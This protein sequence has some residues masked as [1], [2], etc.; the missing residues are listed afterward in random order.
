MSPEV[1]EALRVALRVIDALDALNV[2]YHVGG[3]YASSIHGVP[4]LTQDIDLVA[5]LPTH[6]IDPL[7]ES[8]AEE[9]YIDARSVRE[10]V[11]ERRSF[12]VIHLATGFKVDIFVR[13]ENP[14]DLEEFSRH[15]EVQILDDPPRRIY[16][17]S[18]EDTLLR[19]L[20]WYR[21]GGE[22]S[23]RQWADVVGIVRT[24]RHLDRGYLHRW[25]EIVGV[26]DLLDR[27]LES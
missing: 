14:F 1:P 5:A 26:S 3:S 2:S 13:G 9:F 18:P 7:T 23:E 25:A 4:R 20:M 17:K 11:E 16:V 27:V 21:D 12:N 6:A 8:L 15:Q 19:K 24:S 22:V 10:A